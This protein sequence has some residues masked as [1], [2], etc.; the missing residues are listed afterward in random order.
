MGPVLKVLEPGLLPGPLV[1][2]ALA[3]DALMPWALWLFVRDFPRAPLGRLP[4][5]SFDLAILL[6]LVVGGLAGIGWTATELAGRTWPERSGGL[7]PLARAL[8]GSYYPIL[9]AL[10]A[11]A[12]PWM[13]ARARGAPSLE[14]RRVLLFTSALLAGLVPTTAYILGSAL[15]PG[16]LRLD[17]ASPAGRALL[18]VV[19][20]GPILAVPFAFAYSVLVHRVLEVR[21]VVR[22]ALQYLLARTSLA[23]IAAAPFLLLAGYVWTRRSVTVSELLSD[24]EPLSLL[25]FSSLAIVALATRTRSLSWVDRRFF[26]EQHDARLILSA[27]AQRS[28]GVVSVADLGQLLEEEIDRALHLE[29]VAVLVLNPRTSRLESSTR[30]TR[31][32]D[33]P[34]ALADLLASSVEPVSVESSR[35]GSLAAALP[36]PDRL[37]IAE[38]G[39]RMLVPMIAADGSLVGLAALGEK[40]SELPFERED[41]QLL[42]AIAAS[43]APSIENRLLRSSSFGASDPRSADALRP[44]IE[45]EQ[46][47]WHCPRCGGVF[48]PSAPGCPLDGPVLVKA[49][50]PHVVSG[51][52]RLERR[53]GSGGMGVVYKAFDQGL[54]RMV[55]LKALPRV[56]PELALRLRREARAVAAL[57]HPNLAVIHAAESSF[58]VPILV[59]ELLE[60]GTLASRLERGP[61]DPASILN[62]GVDLA[63]AIEVVHEAGILHRD[64]KPANVGFTGSGIVKVLDFGLSRFIGDVRSEALGGARSSAAGSTDGPEKELWT[65]SDVVVG[66]LGYFSPE[67]AVGEPPDPMFDVWSL[68]VVLYEAA[69][70]RN[71]F[72]GGSVTDV[73]HRIIEA[74]VPDPQTLAPSLPRPLAEYLH[75]ALSRNRRQRPQSA[76]ELRRSLEALRRKT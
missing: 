24:A 26:R 16:L 53:I 13:L 63:S 57:C 25:A 73:L 20:V 30:A 41:R 43:V 22:R 67:A 56:S 45:A 5:A 52:Y 33:V 21:L 54:G 62:L 9:F 38:G 65:R 18:N 14:R 49:G 15:V 69:T 7:A 72:L 36:E 51:K 29:T 23:A 47:A 76:R 58:G 70:G 61:L 2:R 55:A 19:I 75:R 39:F 11:P 66:T 3:V 74:S 48:P 60:G 35:P 50:L 37:W 46:E 27:L 71:P 4:R 34:S 64:L 59:F 10:A 40:K 1:L 8:R 42:S 68:S 44:E 6:S 28:R 12:L 31:H 17:E 32:L